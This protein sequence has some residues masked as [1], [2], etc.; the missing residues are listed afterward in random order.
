[1]LGWLTNLVKG[2]VRL[3][4]RAVTIGWG[5]VLGAPDLIVGFLCVPRKNLRVQFFILSDQSGPV[6]TAA[7]LQPAIDKTREIL[8]QQVNVK[9]LPYGSQMVEIIRD[10][11]P[12]AALNPPGTWGGETGGELWGE[13]GD[14]FAQHLAGWNAVSISAT[15]PITVFVVADVG[16]GKGGYAPLGPLTDYVL[17]D[18]ALIKRTGGVGAGQSMNRP[19]KVLPTR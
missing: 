7:E 2:I 6:V 14:F 17:I 4:V 1:M 5:L 16:N 13:A 15:F 11:A 12:S 10:P 3:V 8:K 9:L 18:P 19:S